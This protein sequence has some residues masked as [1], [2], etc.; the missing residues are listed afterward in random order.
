MSYE[1]IDAQIADWAKEHSLILSTSFANRETRSAYLSSE[2][3]ECFQI[4]VDVP[5]D[6]HVSI[7]ATCVEGR[8][9]N[10]PPREWITNPREV[11]ATLEEVFETIVQW[12][13][14]SARHFPLGKL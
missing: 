11:K 2:L 5:V 12:M 8:K 4:W 14:P 7:Y 10:E 1:L 9:E 6:G 13:T 3:G